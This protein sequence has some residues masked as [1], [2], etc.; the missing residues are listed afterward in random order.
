[1]TNAPYQR[2]G[3]L[4]KHVGNPLVA[5]LSGRLGLNLRGA[6]VLAV[7][8]RRSGEWRTTPVNPLT[9]EG[10]RYLVA[11]RGETEWVRNLRAAG[12]GELRLGRRVQ[13]FRATEVADA[14]KPPILRAYLRQWAWETGNFFDVSGADAPDSELARIA[15]DH[16]VFRLTRRAAPQNQV[17]F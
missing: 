10:Q 15:P 12:A 11:P 6:R 3:W 4:V 17:A 16:P 13:P 14:E 9:V 8:G 5:F 1:M 2:P 7:R